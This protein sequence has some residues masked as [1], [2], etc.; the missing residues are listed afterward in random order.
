MARRQDEFDSWF[1]HSVVTD[2]LGTPIF[3]AHAT[4]DPTFVPALRYGMGP[5]F[6]DEETATNRL[7]QRAEDGDEVDEGSLYWA[8]LRIERPLRMRD[9]HFDELCTFIEGVLDTGVISESEV[10]A[11]CGS[12]ESWYKVSSQQ[13]ADLITQVVGLLRDGGFDGI[14][15]ENHIEGGG[16]LT[17]IPFTLEQ[18]LEAPESPPASDS[19]IPR[20]TIPSLG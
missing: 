13:N 10:R 2:D 6:S 14:A 12:R 7:I 9:V 1:G 11:C 15:Y 19:S 17:W 5:H 8:Y 4:D 3:V 16:S 20:R 18:I